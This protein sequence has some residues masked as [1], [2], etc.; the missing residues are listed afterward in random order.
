MQQW[1]CDGYFE[2]MVTSKFGSLLN[3]RPVLTETRT[4]PR[5]SLNNCLWKNTLIQSRVKTRRISPVPAIPECHPGPTSIRVCLPT[6][7]EPPSCLSVSLLSV[8]CDLLYFT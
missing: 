8:L 6:L 3:T 7:Y 2:E 4:T 1:G 5:T